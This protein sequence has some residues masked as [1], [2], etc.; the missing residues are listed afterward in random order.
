MNM[1][2]PLAN[3]SDIKPCPR[4]GT[5]TPSFNFNNST[6]SIFSFILN[7][8]LNIIC[9]IIINH[10]HNY[11]LKLTAIY[12]RLSVRST[13]IAHCKYNIKSRCH[14][15]TRNITRL[16]RLQGKTMLRAQRAEKFLVYTPACDIVAH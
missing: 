5:T 9:D 6:W 14:G 13:K 2:H 1:Q 8:T 10:S 16:Y 4:F 11:S 3:T 12:T 15:Y 7:V